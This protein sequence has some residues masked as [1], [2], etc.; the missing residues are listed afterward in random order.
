MVRSVNS[1]KARLPWVLGCGLALAVLAPALDPNEQLFYRDT[2]R[3]MYP[4]KQF[5]AGRLRAGQSPFWYP[6]SAAGAPVLAEIT[7]GLFHPLTLL[8]LLLPFELAFKLNHLLTIPLAWLGLYLLARK[9]GAQ[10]WGAAAGACGYAA[11]GYLPSVAGSNLPYAMGAAALPLALHAFLHFAGRPRPLRLLWAAYALALCFYGGD[12]ESMLLCGALGAAWAVGAA[13]PRREA[14]LRSLG[15]TAIWG[16]CALL[17]AAPAMAP[18]LA[19]VAN[20]A[21]A[22][23][24]SQ[25]EATAFANAPARLAG[26][27]VPWAFDD[28]QESATAT[29]PPYY[30]EYFA[31]PHDDAFI[32]SMVLGGPLLLLAFASGRRGQFALLG[33]LFLILGST[34]RATF[35]LRALELA[36]PGLRL[37]RYAEKLIA[38]ASVLV[39]L[40]ASFGV[41]ELCE[42]SR[43]WLP[44]ASGATLAVLSFWAAVRVSSPRLILWLQ[45]HGRSGLPGPAQS[46]VAALDAGLLFEA[47]VLALVAAL[48]FLRLRRPALPLSAALAVLCAVTAYA[49]TAG[50]LHTLPQEVLHAPLLLADELKQAAGPSEFRWRIRGDADHLPVFNGADLR[51]WRMEA[52]AQ[53]LNPQFHA[54]ARIESASEYGSLDDRDYHAA[55]AG[56]PGAANAVLGVRFDILPRQAL[57]AGRAAA[58][59]YRAAAFGAW[60]KPFPERPR[61]FLAGCARAIQP[62]P[63]AVQWLASERFRLDEAV[64]RKEVRLPCPA[65]P[66]GEVSLSRSAPDRMLARTAS[67]APALLIVAEHFDK[68]WQATVDGRPAEVLQADLTALGVAVPEG[69]HEVRLRFVP[70]LLWLGLGLAAACA[71]ALLLLELLH[72]DHCV[73]AAEA[74]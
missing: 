51:L 55:L 43:R 40:A 21:R 61:A 54:L 71:A 14:V 12:P 11:C 60:V 68:G 67:S 49:Q 15:L 33:A 57:T 52:A 29:N 53:I 45:V 41:S 58:A 66:A 26:L 47:A 22:E 65:N 19:R 2:L 42:K 37:F 36:I 8:Y 24:L 23:A 32:D 7:P 39:C 28:T 35:V 6:W 63:E 3:Y 27:L 10:P 34:G 30:A 9:A 56:A 25:F 4:F 73:G 62:L 69:K 16:A 17:L 50:L 38:P 1:V 44:I 20:N 46:F 70:H 18:A 48:L 59:G 72:R 13:L 5:I 74:E 64:V 31:G